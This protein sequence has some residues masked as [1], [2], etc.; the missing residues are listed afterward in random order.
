MKQQEKK[1]YGTPIVMAKDDELRLFAAID[2]ILEIKASDSKAVKAEKTK[3][4]EAIKLYQ[5]KYTRAKPSKS[6]PD[7][8]KRLT[9]DRL[10]EFMDC[11]KLGYKDLFEICCGEDGERA[12]LSWPKP[13]ETEMCKLLDAAGEDR[14]QAIKALILDAL[15]A[16]I[17]DVLVLNA[18]SAE[19]LFELASLRERLFDE[20]NILIRGDVQLRSAR[21]NWVSSGAQRER[22]W[23][24]LA[25]SK[26]ADVTK[27]F[28]VSYHWLCGLGSDVTVLAKTGSTEE[29]MDAFCMLPDDQKEIIYAG[30]KLAEK[31][32]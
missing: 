6:A 14:K 32:A 30:A 20:A 11:A 16:P 3:R 1:E 23:K 24:T 10:E 17:R 8:P 25:F 5:K 22:I 12:R 21:D 4:A 26:Y 2:K 9:F 13:I 29:I 7:I 31:E 19:K 18:Q 28:D 27:A 15:P